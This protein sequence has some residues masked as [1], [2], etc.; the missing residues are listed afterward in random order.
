M[1]HPIIESRMEAMQSVLMAVY[2]AGTK[3]PSNVAG[4]ER[5][6]FVRTYLKEIFPSPLRF[7]S[8]VITDSDGNTSGQLDIVVER[9]F[10]PSFP[11]PLGEERL[12]LADNVGAVIEVKSDLSSQWSELNRTTEAVYGLKYQEV[13]TGVASG[14]SLKKIPVLAVGYRGYKSPEGIKNRLDTTPPESRPNGVLC[15]ES[16]CCLFDI[17]GK[18]GFGK[19]P[20]GLFMFACALNH[21]L[22]RV[23]SN[24]PN[25]WDYREVTKPA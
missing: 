23:L 24:M 22:V 21:L 2:R 6:V 16:G 17:A 4:R 8:G 7:G 15:I 10:A 9:P 14:Q 19:G 20:M 12:F 1:N 5:E 13:F 3:I 25:L 18:K 11:M